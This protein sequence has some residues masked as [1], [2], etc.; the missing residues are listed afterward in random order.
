MAGVSCD[1]FQLDSFAHKK[2]KCNNS[3]TNQYFV[4][5]SMTARCANQWT[6]DV[7]TRGSKLDEFAEMEWDE[8]PLK[9]KSHCHVL[10][11]GNAKMGAC[12]HLQVDSHFSSK[13]VCTM[14]MTDHLSSY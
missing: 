3:T 1:D 13:Y 6:D 5:A 7:T 10:L 2:H 8:V 9:R 4:G 14:E 11:W 12:G